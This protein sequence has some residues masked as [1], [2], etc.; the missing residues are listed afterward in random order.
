MVA[1]TFK[2][3]KFVVDSNATVQNQELPWKKYLIPN[4]KS[5]R[6]T[7]FN[8][9][10]ED[11]YKS[12]Y[13]AKQSRSQAYLDGQRHFRWEISCKFNNVERNIV[14]YKEGTIPKQN[15]NCLRYR[16][17]PQDVKPDDVLKCKRA[18]SHIKGSLKEMDEVKDK[19]M[20][21]KRELF[22]EDVKPKP[23]ASSE[24][25]FVENFL[26]KISEIIVD[27][28]KIAMDLEYVLHQLEKRFSKAE[29]DTNERKRKAR[30]VIEQKYKTKR[31]QK[32]LNARKSGDVASG[33]DED[34][35]IDILTDDDI[36]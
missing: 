7:F 11:I 29:V 10:T 31:K 9:V 30:R 23:W 15:L 33:S 24:I 22:D 34:G 3:G 12:A 26:A 6:L 32:I 14:S 25:T 28:E 35:I 36:D 27:P 21:R 5:N 19:L 16:V 13:V 8:S 20:N 4:V 18:L 1:I 2:D 17:V